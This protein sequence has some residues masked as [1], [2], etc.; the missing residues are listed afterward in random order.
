MTKAEE[1]I[2]D[3]N[4]K[5]SYNKNNYI[6]SEVSVVRKYEVKELILASL[7]IAG[8]LYGRHKIRNK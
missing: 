5:Y 1:M 8:V 4:L 7:L 3:Y 2:K 6:L